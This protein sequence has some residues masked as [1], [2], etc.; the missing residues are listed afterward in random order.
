MYSVCMYAC[1]PE[2]ALDIITDG[3]EPLCNCWKLN[4]GPL[5]L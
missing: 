3:Y 4:S 5:N 2:D 1:R